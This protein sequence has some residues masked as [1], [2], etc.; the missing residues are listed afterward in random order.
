M[1]FVIATENL[2]QY[3]KILAFVEIEVNR[4]LFM[5]FEIQLA[6]SES[7]HG[8]QCQIG[9]GLFDKDLGRRRTYSMADVAIMTDSNSG[10]T[11]ERAK[12]L[13]VELIAMPFLVNDHVYFEG[14]DL[15]QEQFFRY[16]QE[17]AEVST[18]QPAPG[19]L[20]DTWKRLLQTHDEV[21]YIPMSGGLSNS[22]MT[23]LALSQ[24]YDGKVQVVDNKRISVPQYQSVLD[25][26][27]LA[28]R[29]LDAA[30]I[31]K[32]L[33][34]TAEIFSIYVTVDTLKYLKKGGRISG[35]AAVLGTMLNVKPVLWLGA[36]QLEAVSK[37]RGMK[38][39]RR[40]MLE[41]MKKD[42]EGRLKPWYDQ[43]RIRLMTAYTNVSEE[44]IAQWNQ[45]VKDVLGVSEVETAPLTLSIS[46]HLG[47][48]ALAVGA[49]YAES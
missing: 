39:A 6:D 3:N 19:V 33:E 43:G 2:F 46:C 7:P 5:S 47:P 8:Q 16:L 31:K 28:E 21:V 37:C 10:M 38:A 48:G 41:L 13:G 49:A 23:A 29:G 36:D 15:S 20:V 44:Q 18:S 1:C 12:E 17:D 32:E 40:T 24:E 4:L 22:C 34:R 14:I 26:L 11:Q 9:I 35:T 30:G 45:E 25:A 42:L 27:L